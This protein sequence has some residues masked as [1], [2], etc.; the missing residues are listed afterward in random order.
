V[1][2]AAKTSDPNAHAQL[3]VLAQQ[4]VKLAEQHEQFER[5]SDGTGLP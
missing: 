2:R 3:V 1:A 5:R 4:W